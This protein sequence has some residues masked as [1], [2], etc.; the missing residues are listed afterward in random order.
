MTKAAR[1]A[2]RGCACAAV[3]A[4]PL[5][6]GDEA[7]LRLD[8]ATSKVELTLVATLH[9]GASPLASRSSTSLSLVPKSAM[10]TSLAPGG[11]TAMM[12]LPTA[13]TSDG[14]PGMMPARS[15]LEAIPT[16]PATTPAA[17]P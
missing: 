2:L 1:M 8:A 16:A 13:T 4:F 17:A 11:C 12:K 7:P 3:L 5:L 9:T 15:S 10:A 14:I 6:R